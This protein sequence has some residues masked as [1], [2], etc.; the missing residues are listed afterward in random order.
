[1]TASEPSPKWNTPDGAEPVEITFDEAHEAGPAR[2]AAETS[3][4]RTALERYVRTGRDDRISESG[5]R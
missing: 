4:F 2:I 3:E 5:D 1:M